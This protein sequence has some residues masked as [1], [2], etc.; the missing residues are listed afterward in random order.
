MPHVDRENNSEP[1]DKP[2]QKLDIL[3]GDDSII[4][5]SK[6][7]DVLQGPEVIMDKTYNERI[8]IMSSL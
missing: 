6:K 5:D 3:T 7:K 2:E 1:T 4:T 8:T